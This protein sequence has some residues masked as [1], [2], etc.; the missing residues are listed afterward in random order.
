MKKEEK[1]EPVRLVDENDPSLTFVNTHV[2]GHDGAKGTEYVYNA[3]SNHTYDEEVATEFPATNDY[4]DPSPTTDDEEDT[5]EAPG[6]G[7]GTMGLVLAI[8]SLFFVPLLLGVAGA[9]CGVI[10]WSKGARTLGVW[11]IIIAVAS[12]VGTLLFSPYL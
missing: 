6:K 4:V 11:S 9:I 10:A 3:K 5:F 1:N 8:T 7:I 2:D 12:V